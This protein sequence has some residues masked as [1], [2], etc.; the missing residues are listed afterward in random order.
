MVKCKW[1]FR[2]LIQLLTMTIEE[3]DHFSLV[4]TS[5]EHCVSVSSSLLQN[6]ELACAM[7]LLAAVQSRRLKLRKNAA[8]RARSAVQ[9]SRVEEE[10]EFDLPKDPL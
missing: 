9:S 10:G 5:D 6:S 3:I 2:S 7:R 4:I 8:S 1:S